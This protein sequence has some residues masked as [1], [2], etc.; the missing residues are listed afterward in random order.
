[1]AAGELGEFLSEFEEFDE[2]EQDRGDEDRFE[3]AE[4]LI[5]VISVAGSN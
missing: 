3:N 5:A 2:G 4:L 1:M